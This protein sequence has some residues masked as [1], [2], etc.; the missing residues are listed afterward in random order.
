LCDKI[1]FVKSLYL[2]TRDL[3]LYAGLFLS[4]FILVF[5]VSV[6]AIA[7]M[8]TPA[9]ADPPVRTVT[10]LNLP[11]ELAQ[12][13]GREQATRLHEILDPI[14]VHGEIN[15]V[16]NIAAEGRLVVPVSVPGREME[17][18]LY[19]ASGTARITERANS[20]WNSVVYLHKM[21][22]PHNAALRG[23]WV[24]I[25][26]WRWF[27]DATA[28]GTL[29]I[30]VSGIYLWTALKAERRVGFALLS[31]GALSFFGLVLALAL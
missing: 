14:G 12:L 31:A 25:R 7:H 10:G 1:P 22:G 29:F 4:P 30:T 13:K 26:I 9:A 28:Y 24:Y 6:F 27:A 11:P 5:A 20:F 16:R 2:L 3:H 21:P 15:F 19:P 18:S 23:N 17:I 8:K